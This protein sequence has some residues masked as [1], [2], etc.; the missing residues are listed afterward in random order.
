MTARDP[1]LDSRI[2][3]LDRAFNDEE[4]V[5]LLLTLVR[6]PDRDARKMLVQRLAR[7]APIRDSGRSSAS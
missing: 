6:R 3:E 5:D 1:E 2:H 7:R 4:L